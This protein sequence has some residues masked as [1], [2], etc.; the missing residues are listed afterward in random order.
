MSKQRISVPSKA[1]EKRRWDK[2]F[3]KMLVGQGADLEAIR[4]ADGIKRQRFDQW[5]DM[6]MELIKANNVEH[7]WAIVGLIAKLSRDEINFV[8]EEA[9]VWVDEYVPRV[10]P[11]SW[12]MVQRAE[13]GA[14]FRSKDGRVVILSGSTE[15]DGRRWLHMSMSRADRLPSWE[16]LREGKEIFIGDRTAIQ[17]FPKKDKYVNIHPNVLHVWAWIDGEEILPDFT[18]GSGSI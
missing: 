15:Q 17:V 14:A 2:V 5:Y 12:E 3:F 4:K 8:E 1:A 11:A 13:D 9:P 16:D 10:L 18:R 6:A 7:S